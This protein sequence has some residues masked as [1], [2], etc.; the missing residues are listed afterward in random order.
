MINT[1]FDHE[2]EPA[3][4]KSGEAMIDLFEGRELDELPII[5]TGDFNSVA[6][7]SG[8]YSTLVTDGPTLD[9]WDVATE[10]LTPAWGTFPGYEEPVD[11]G[12][13]INW[14]LVTEGI[15]THQAAINVWRG[16]SGAYPSD[17]APV[18]ALISLP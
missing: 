11:G 17:H 6:H 14:V 7:D 9:T 16:G 10:Q 13:R 18:H 12:T 2:S 3:R 1:H 8:A 15:T 5:V 4:I